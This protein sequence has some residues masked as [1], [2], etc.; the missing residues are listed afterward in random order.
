MGGALATAHAERDAY[1]QTLGVEPE[2]AFVLQLDAE[3]TWTL[4]VLPSALAAIEAEAWAS[5]DG[6]ETGGWLIGQP[7][8]T[9]QQTVLYATGPGPDAERFDGAI[10][11]DRAY[12]ERVARDSKAEILGAWHTHPTPACRVHTDGGIISESDAS[13]GSRD[14]DE[15]GDWTHFEV[16]VTPAYG[17]GWS[18]QTLHPYVI[19]AQHGSEAPVIQRARFK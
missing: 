10:I 12:G 19:E 4:D 2:R 13:I 14:L 15:R 17:V 18:E 1:W 7:T 6:T 11:L 9:R 16:I 8:W 5:D 3:P